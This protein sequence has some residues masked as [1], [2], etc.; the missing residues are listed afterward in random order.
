MG[1]HSKIETALGSRNHIGNFSSIST[2]FAGFSVS[3]K[4]SS[5]SERPFNVL[6][7][8]VDT[9][10]EG[11]YIA[12][13]RFY[14]AYAF[15]FLLFR[16]Y[17]FSGGVDF[18]A[19]NM[20]VKGTPSVGDKSEF[21]PDANSGIWI[22][23]EHFHLGISVN[24]IFNG[25]LQPYQEVSQMRRHFNITV[26]RLF[27]I[28]SYFAVKSSFLVRFPAYLDYNADYT[29]E[30]YVTDIIGGFSLRRKLGGAFWL[31]MK[32]IGIFGGRLEAVLCY[33]TPLK[34]SLVNL[35]SLEII[36]RYGL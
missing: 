34:G 35:S 31:G 25:R 20:T 18:G 27:T 15:H 7:L 6:G 23:N 29:V 33:N 26:M 5:R 1:S 10:Q 32:D 30:C 24:Q 36:C 3:I 13:N 11:K 9:D 16:D 21:V 17:H 2:Y 4:S 8:K 12:R 19:L 14:A 22:Y 28:N